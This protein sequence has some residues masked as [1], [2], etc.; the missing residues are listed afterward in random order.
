[1][2]FLFHVNGRNLE[3]NLAVSLNYQFPTHYSEI[4]PDVIFYSA[5]HQQIIRS[6]IIESQNIKNIEPERFSMNHRMVGTQN[7][8]I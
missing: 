1:M 7:W 2:Q 4:L 8:I 6:L 3:I 5:D